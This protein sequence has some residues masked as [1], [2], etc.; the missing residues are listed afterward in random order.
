MKHVLSVQDISCVGKCSLT[1]ALP[2]LS[3]M[4]CRCS[5]LPTAVLSTHTA[6]P[7]PHVRDLTEDLDSVRCHWQRVG[8]SFDAI[9]VGYL[10]NPA[11]AQAV[12]ALLDAFPA[13]TVIDPVMGDHGRLYSGITP[14]HVA[15]MRT[16]CRR[17]NILLPNVTEAALLTGIPYRPEYDP[18]Y[19]R[20]LTAG[21]LGFGTEAVVITGVCTENRTIGFAGFH[22]ETGDFSCQLP[23]IPRQQHGTGDLFAAVLTGAL[24]N[25]L[26]LPE[27]AA[28]AAEFVANVLS[29]AS[30]PSPFGAD[31]EPQLP[32]LWKK[33]M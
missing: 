17:G 11:Q 3:A 22:R 4:Q 1:V 19:Y 12:C 27:A 2:V 15:A 26:A 31:F 9:S 30:E 8:V 25:G 16:L 5:V 14:D 23:Q 29:S 6:F 28:L 33:L 10:A 20:E 13:L 21:M 24:M 18:G 7:G 32:W